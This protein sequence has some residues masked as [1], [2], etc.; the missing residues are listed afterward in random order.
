MNNSQQSHHQHQ[1]VPA[2]SWKDSRKGTFQSV[3]TRVFHEDYAD[4]PSS[5]SPAIGCGDDAVCTNSTLSYPQHQRTVVK[6]TRKQQYSTA[7]LQD[8]MKCLMNN[9]PDLWNEFKDEL[10]REENP[11]NPETVRRVLVDFLERHGDVVQEQQLQTTTETN[12]EETAA[13]TAA[14]AQSANAY[15]ND[16]MTSLW[17]PGTSPNRR[18][19]R[20][21]RAQSMNHL[22]DSLHRSLDDEE[23]TETSNRMLRP[24]VDSTAWKPGRK[25]R[26]RRD[27]HQR[28]LSMDHLKDSLHRDSFSEDEEEEE[29]GEASP[30]PRSLRRPNVRKRLT[31]NMDKLRPVDFSD[32]VSEASAS[33]HGD[34]DD[35][36]EEEGMSALNGCRPV[37]PSSHQQASSLSHLHATQEKLERLGRIPHLWAL[38]QSERQTSKHAE[39]VEEQGNGESHEKEEEAL[40]AATTLELFW[41]E[42]E[43]DILEYEQNEKK[44]RAD[45]AEG[46][47][48]DA[49]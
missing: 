12:G 35:D 7:E 18:R 22:K 25:H 32:D 44:E 39:E 48:E 33:F 38:Y 34:D 17:K 42:H 2:C 27:R 8:K 19:P 46:D 21:Q 4:S 29:A 9:H 30:S 49:V 40:L 24:S 5:A 20:H 13:S 41:L 14:S 36:D 10:V 45:K 6:K 28:A 16:H 23:T 15:N 47:V 31:P 11:T 1:A 37:V 26:N 3:S 43:K